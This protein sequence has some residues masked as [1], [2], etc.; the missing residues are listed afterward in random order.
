MLLDSAIFYVS[1]EPLLGMDIVSVV[2]LFSVIQGLR[3]KFV[4][5]PAVASEAPGERCPA[6]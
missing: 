3:N 4:F 6:S 2:F 5:D 1:V